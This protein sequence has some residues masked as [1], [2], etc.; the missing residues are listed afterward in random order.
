MNNKRNYISTY[1]FILSS[2]CLVLFLAY[3]NTEKD[4]MSISNNKTEEFWVENDTNQP[5]LITNSLEIESNQINDNVDIED[6]NE[7][8]LSENEDDID[9]LEKDVKEAIKDNFFINK[10]IVTESIDDDKTS[11]TFREPI[12]SYK[13]ITTLDKNVVKNINYYP[14]LYVWTSI[15]TEDIDFINNKP[16]NLSLNISCNNNE[17]SNLDFDITAKTPRWREWVEIDLSNLETNTYN[18]VWNVKIINRKDD[19]VIES[20]VFKFNKVENNHHL[21]EI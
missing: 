6:T 7:F 2:F 17:I 11:A 4:I 1:I 19:S 13:T 5:V 20:R 14:N 21:S 9:Y 3:N 15:N 16:L 18:G 10:I 8:N 12:N